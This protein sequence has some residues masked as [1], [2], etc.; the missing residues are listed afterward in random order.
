MNHTI[1]KPL[2]LPLIL[3]LGIFIN[4]CGESVPA[5]NPISEEGVILAFGDSLTHGTGAKPEESYP[6]VLSRLTSRPVV[7][8]GIPGELSAAGKERLPALLEEH[9]PQLLILCHGGNDLLRKKNKNSMKNNL[10]AMVSM[11]RER[12]IQVVLL[13]VPEPKLFLLESAEVY[14]NLAK[15]LLIPIEDKVLPEVLG[16]SDLKSDAIHPN[17]QGYSK[18][19]HAISDLLKRAKALN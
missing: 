17:A 9:E 14:K 12:G 11:A 16:D 19:A 3:I 7:N 18:V 2:Y 8:A 6:S 4:A 10:K 13:G 15:E 1:N 5:L